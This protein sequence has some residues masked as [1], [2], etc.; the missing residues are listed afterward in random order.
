MAQDDLDHMPSI[1]PSREAGADYG[2]SKSRGSKPDKPRSG[3]RPPAGPGNG[4]GGNGS[5]GAGVLA[6]LFIAVALVVAGGACY[7][8][9]QLQ[10]QLEQAN[11]QME[12]YAKR[13]G[14]LEARLSDTDEGLSQNTEAMAVKIKELF[15]EVDKLWASA[16]RRNKAAIEELEK[17]SASQ[18]RKVAAAEKTIAANET[19]LKS[20]ASDIA[21][22]K[23]VA[24][25]LERLMASAKANQTEVERVA[26]SLNRVNVELTRLSKRVGDNEEWVNSINAFR[27]Q[28]NRTISELQ[29]SVRNLQSTP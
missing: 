14:D 5:G 21:R 9:F 12:R 28:I 17:T 26:D 18:V 10:Q 16:W 20:A 8:A 1:V 24:G 7:W 15:A 11:A 29:T 2:T 22:L 4:G 13:I 19:Q 27:A 23:S 6:R 25:D 3:Q